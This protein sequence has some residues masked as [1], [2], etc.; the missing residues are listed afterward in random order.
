MGYDDTYVIVENLR[1]LLVTMS[2]SGPVDPTQ[3]PLFIGRRFKYTGSSPSLN[4]L[5]FNLGAAGY[6]LNRRALDVL[7]TGIVT[8]SCDSETS[9]Y[10][11]DMFVANCLKQNS[12]FP[13]DTRDESGAERFHPLAPREM[14]DSAKPDWYTKAVADYSPKDGEE[15]VS[16]ETITFHDLPS[17]IMA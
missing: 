15:G 11:A 5:T 6:A 16:K 3:Q 2:V 10:Y 9:E 8:R 17:T 7:A 14:F 1:R 4:G 13:M 12:I